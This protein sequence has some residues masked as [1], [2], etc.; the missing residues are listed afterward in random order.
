MPPTWTKT[1]HLHGVARRAAA[2]GPAAHLARLDKVDR[3]E[4]RLV[5]LCRN[6]H[7]PLHR[8]AR[9]GRQRLDGRPD[10][11]VQHALTLPVADKARQLIGRRL[12]IWPCG[13]FAT[14]TCTK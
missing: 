6:G 10:A 9:Q 8:R 2:A 12:G 5:I 13:L 14:L 11:V 7:V 3:A 4:Q 1:A